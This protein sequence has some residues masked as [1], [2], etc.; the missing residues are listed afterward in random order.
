MIVMMI[1][2]ICMSPS[3]IAIGIPIDSILF[4]VDFSGLKSS[5][6]RTMLFFFIITIREIKT[7]IACERVVP[8]AAPAGPSPN[9]P[10]KR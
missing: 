8:R 5:C 2:A 7:L 10:I 4:I 9:T 3:C 1:N 6:L